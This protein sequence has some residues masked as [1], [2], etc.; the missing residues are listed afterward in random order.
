MSAR[1]TAA[2][3]GRLRGLDVLSDARGIFALAAI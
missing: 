1:E 3:L 2:R